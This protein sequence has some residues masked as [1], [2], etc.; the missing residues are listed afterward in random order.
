MNVLVVDIGGTW[1]RLAV[2]RRTN[3]AHNKN[4]E[5][6]GTESG[7]G[8]TPGTQRW[9]LGPALRVR[10]RDFASFDA[11]LDSVASQVTQASGPIT[12]VGIALAGPVAGTGLRAWGTPTNL[13]W[14]KLEAHCIAQR[15][16]LPVALINDFAA[17][18]RSLSALGSED[19]LTLQA[20]EPE[21]DGLCLVVGAGTG[22]GTC[23]VTQAPTVRVYP[24]EGGHAELA[25]HDSQQ[26]E[27]AA[28]IRTRAGRCSR[29]H[30]LSGGGIARMA[31]F[32][33]E[34]Q[35]DPD[36]KRTLEQPDPAGAI[37]QL[38]RTGNPLALT[39]MRW[40]VQ[41][42]AEQVADIALGALPRAGVFIAGG[43]AP[44]WQDLFLAPDF[45][46]AFRRKPPMGKLMEQLPVHLVIHPEPGLLGIAVAAADPLHPTGD[47]A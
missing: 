45:L 14:P 37:G 40:F 12:A 17:I 19:R 7:H 24:G 29:E 31:E 8:D 36:L 30:V 43:I 18:G 1:T 9:N 3:E 2:A 33:L 21:A 32:L 10:S 44:Q 25:P 38:A 6:P 26:A 23:L 16:S 47:L 11:L 39:V 34:R 13:P 15:L 41:M 4:P 28:W 46:E 5:S 27:L 42:L 35:Q 20:G 22:L